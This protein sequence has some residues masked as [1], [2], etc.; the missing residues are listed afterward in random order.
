MTKLLWLYQH[1]EQIGAGIISALVAW[2]P[3][4]TL[5]ARFI[6][7]PAADAHWFK[8]LAFDLFVDTPALVAAIG[9]AGIFGGTFNFPGV[10]SR[11]M[12]DNPTP[13]VSRM[14]RV[15]KA[16]ASVFGASEDTKVDMRTPGL[17]L[18]FLLA[19]GLAG[20]MMA[21]SGCGTAGGA[22]LGRCEM[23]TIPQALESLLARVVAAAFSSGSDWSATLEQAGKDAA[24][25]QVSCLVQAVAGWLEE[26]TAGKKGQIDESY[27]EAHRRMRAYLDTHAAS[28]A[29]GDLRRAMNELRDPDT[30][31]FGGGG[32]SARF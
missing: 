18:P 11:M 26:L 19:L 21:C 4:A 27:V 2:I 14:M 24:P 16:H 17:L 13:S 23:N 28:P 29:C 20:M 32:A 22:A 1:R 7:R 30:M 12:A 15:R 31:L 25:G 5:L 8:R 3:V 6:R 10:P 9:R